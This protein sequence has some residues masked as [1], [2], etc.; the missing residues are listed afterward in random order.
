[1]PKQLAKSRH[2]LFFIIGGIL[3]LFMIVFLVIK[4]V[5][6]HPVVQYSE[7]EIKTFDRINS[8]VQTYKANEDD[9]KERMQQEPHK[10]ESTMTGEID[11]SDNHSF[12]QVANWLHGLL[13][14]TEFGWTRYHHPQLLQST[15]EVDVN[16]QSIPLV[17]FTLYQ[18]D[19]ITAVESPL[20]FNEAIGLHNDQFGLLLEKLESDSIIDI[21][22]NWLKWQNESL[23]TRERIRLIKTYISIF[24]EGI[25]KAQIELTED[26]LFEGEK[27]NYYKAHMNE[28]D[29]KTLLK[30]LLQESFETN[31]V[32]DFV[33][34]FYKDGD[35]FDVLLTEIDALQLPNGLSFEA[36]FNDDYVAH[37]D[38]YTT[39]VIFGK[40]IDLSITLDTSIDKND[41]IQM[42]ANVSINFKNGAHYDMNYNMAGEPNAEGYR[43][44]QTVSLD[45]NGALEKELLTASIQSIYSE[46]KTDTYVNVVPGNMSSFALAGQLTRELTMDDDTAIRQT[47]SQFGIERFNDTLDE[48][49][50]YLLLTS[51]DEEITFNSQ[52]EQAFI[53]KSDVLF[54]DQLVGEEI[55][56]L[57]QKIKEGITDNIEQLLR[58]WIPFF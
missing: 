39:V 53:D 46:E 37:R 16:L 40:E 45:E 7:A 18:D 48:E 34:H 30:A 15:V 11:F 38:L 49:E 41:E 3:V 35:I 43:I 44:E 25:Q 27:Y 10:V 50:S 36:Y 8:I 5:F 9:L 31:F 24:L 2:R 55:K 32:D 14:T 52:F 54:L 42:E 56:D 47:D 28:M 23:T 57:F 12:G 21:L 29:T 6:S 20:I 58:R 26:V 1:M 17:N 22:P 33:K 19:E 4:F 13:P 51:I